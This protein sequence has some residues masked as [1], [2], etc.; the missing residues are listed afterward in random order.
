MIDQGGDYALA[1]KGS[2]GK[3][4]DDVKLFLDD[5]DTLVAQA[6]QVS[7]GHGRIETRIA[8]VSPIGQQ[9]GGLVAGMA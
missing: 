3:L 2:Q 8:S 4:Y 9:S 6:S 5:L 7:K 1:L